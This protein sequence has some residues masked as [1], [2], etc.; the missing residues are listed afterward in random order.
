[1]SPLMI[2]GWT[3]QREDSAD[4]RRLLALAYLVRPSGQRIRHLDDDGSPL[5]DEQAGDDGKLLG[6][7]P[8]DAAAQAR[9]GSARTL[10][11]FSGEPDCFHITLYILGKDEWTEGFSL[12]E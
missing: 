7:C 12:A 4:D 1:M 6:V 3:V 5:R 10:P 2:S 11:G 8:S 9:I